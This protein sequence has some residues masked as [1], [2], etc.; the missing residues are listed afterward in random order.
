MKVIADKMRTIISIIFISIITNGCGLIDSN[1][2]TG[3]V[4]N[5]SFKLTDT[6]GNVANTFYSGKEFDMHFM[7][8]N[9]TNHAITYKYAG[10]P[11]V[12]FQILKN[13]SDIAGSIYSFPNIMI[14]SPDTLKVGDTIQVMWK[15]QNYI[16]V[17]QNSSLL[18]PPGSYQAKVLYPTFNGVNVK[19]TSLIGFSVIQ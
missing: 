4:I 10:A 1:P 5:A 8:I 17:T 14:I 12:H 16:G 9:T 18:L 11:P 15:A 13:D 6:S 2:S 7:L 3:E 19:C